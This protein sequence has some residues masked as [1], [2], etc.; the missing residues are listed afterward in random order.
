MNLRKIMMNKRSIVIEVFV[1]MG[2]IYDF[3]KRFFKG[4]FVIID[5]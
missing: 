5:K 1:L 2:L 3:D 4:F